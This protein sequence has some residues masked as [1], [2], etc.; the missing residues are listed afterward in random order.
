MNERGKE[1]LKGNVVLH[2]TGIRWEQET[3]IIARKEAEEP[4]GKFID[5]GSCVSHLGI[6]GYQNEVFYGMGRAHFYIF[7]KV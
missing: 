1:V 4:K 6:S 7:T 2:Q 3:R 5:Y